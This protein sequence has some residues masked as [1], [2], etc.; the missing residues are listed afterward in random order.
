LIGLLVLTTRCAQIGWHQ[1]KSFPKT[2]PVGGENI[3]L[4]EIILLPLWLPSAHQRKNDVTHLLDTSAFLAYYFGEA[5]MDRVRDIL[6]DSEYKVGMSVVSATEFW[7]R[8]KAENHETV[9]PD[10]WTEYRELFELVE[11]DETVAL[12][13]VELRGAAEGRLPT[14][15]SLIAACAANHNAILVHRDP[16]F[17]NIPETHLQ[18]EFLGP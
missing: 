1:S 3:S 8:L 14:V 12:K 10:E 6:A 5:G 7:A 17:Q 11:I 16:H 2:L 18:Q 4:L 15:D 13:S 9:F